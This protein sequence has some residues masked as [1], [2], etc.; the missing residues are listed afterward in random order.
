MS[1]FKYLLSQSHLTFSEAE[2]DDIGGLGGSKSKAFSGVQWLLV[3]F[4]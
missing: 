1:G 3:F 4:I 2:T